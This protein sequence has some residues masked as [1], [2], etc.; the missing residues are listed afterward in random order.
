MKSE[1]TKQAEGSIEILVSIPWTRIDEQYKKILTEEAESSE[2]KGFRKGKAPIDLVEKHLDKN[3]LYEKVIEKI[4]PEIYKNVIEDY[5]LRPV[6]QPK[7]ELKKAKEKEDWQILIITCEKPVIDLADYKKNIANISS[8]TENKIWLPGEKPLDKK[9]VDEKKSLDQILEA[10]FSSVK[11]TIPMILIEQETNRLLSNLI[12]QTQKLG[13]TIEQ[14]M[15]SSGK[16][17]EIVKKDFMDQ[18]KKTLTL[19]FALE[20]ISESEKIIVTEEDIDAAINNVKNEE[21]KKNLTRERYYLASV[22]RRNKTL[23]YLM[24]LK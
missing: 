23:N 1:M 3:K 17:I 22:L 7:I 19:E 12:D 20:E 11:I 21:E 8:K 18:A 9:P 15:A 10:L 2:I 16:S 6:I 4:L 24:S 14:Y 13:L 5:K